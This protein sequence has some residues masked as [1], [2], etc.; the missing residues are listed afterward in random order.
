MTT[1]VYD[2]KNKQIAVDSRA[3][4]GG[5]IT[6]DEDVKWF[7]IKNELWVMCGALCDKEVIIKAFESGDRAYEIKEIPDANAIVFRDGKVFMRG[8]TE[9]GEA[10]TQELTHNRCLGSGSSFALAALDHG[11]S[12]REAVQYAATRDC[13]T[14]GKVHVFDIESCR[15]LDE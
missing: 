15:F 12:A 1:I 7:Y 2:H 11:K 14:G 13:Y 4:S 8:V 5:L 9:T 10:W 6:S 3:T